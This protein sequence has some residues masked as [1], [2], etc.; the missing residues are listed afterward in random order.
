METVLRII[1]PWAKACTLIATMSISCAVFGAD[2]GVDNISIAVGQSAAL[3]GPAAE[4][5]TRAWALAG[6]KMPEPMVRMMSPV[7]G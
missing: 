6:P 7:G 2:V 1:Q 3:T 5:T 4:L